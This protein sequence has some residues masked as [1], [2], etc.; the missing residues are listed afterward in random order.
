MH[1]FVFLYV[2]AVFQTLL[3]AIAV[4]QN[5]LYPVAVFQTLLH[6]VAVFQT[7][8]GRRGPVTCS[9]PGSQ[10]GG[11][12]ESQQQTG[13]F[14]V[15]T[16]ST[17]LSQWSLADLE[18][19]KPELL[20]CWNNFLVAYLISKQFRI[21][22]EDSCKSLLIWVHCLRYFISLEIHSLK[23]KCQIWCTVQ[24]R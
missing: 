15:V 13:T 12:Q 17:V 1:V 4:F 2:V 16:E 24:L 20:L 3:Y 7:H 23:K 19:I 8:S 9:S 11:G 21:R 18:S 22:S 14:T 6:P 10:R 5:L